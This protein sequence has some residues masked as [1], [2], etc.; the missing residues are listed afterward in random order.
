MNDARALLLTG[1][2]GAGKSAVAE[3][4]ADLL[5]GGASPY[6]AIDLDWLCEN[7][8]PIRK[9]AARVLGLAGWSPG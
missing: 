8:G 1:V 6:A 9:T 7:V 3:E 2:F 4:I 5:E